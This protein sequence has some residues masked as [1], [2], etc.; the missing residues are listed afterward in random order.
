MSLLRCVSVGMWVPYTS[1]V[2]IVCAHQSHHSK[3]LTMQLLRAAGNHLLHRIVLSIANA[4]THL[5]PVISA[6]TLP[7]RTTHI[8]TASAP[9]H[10]S[11]WVRYGCKPC[12][13]VVTLPSRT[14][15]T[16]C[17]TLPGLDMAASLAVKWSPYHP[18]PLTQTAPLYLG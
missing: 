2:S 9:L 18:G 11:T 13:E 1:V 10:H 12:S 16:D 7:S 14:T 15:H 5:W 3:E 8:D 6:Q 17:A 4:Y